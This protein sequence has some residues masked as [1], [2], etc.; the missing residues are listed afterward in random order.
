M[1]SMNKIIALITL[2]SLV[3]PI[4]ASGKLAEFS[5]KAQGKPQIA[6]LAESLSPTVVYI[7]SKEKARAMPNDPF[8]Y[9][10]GNP[11]GEQ[12]PRMR[13]GAGSGVLVSSEGHIIT[14]YHVIQDATEIQVTLNDERV[15]DAEIVGTDP[16]I[17]LAVLK[18]KADHLTYAA[19]G[20]SS[21]LR[22]GE[23]VIAIGAPLGYR[24]TV[25]Q[26]IISALNRGG[27][28]RLNTI[29]NYIQTDAA[30]NRGN[31]GGPLIDMN[32]KIIG[33]NTAISAMGQNIGFAVPID[34]IKSSYAQIME[35]GTVSRGALG[36]TI[37]SLSPEAKE[38]YGQTHGAIVLSVKE[39][40]PAQR[41]GLQK[42]DLILSLDGVKVRDSGHLTS[43]VA[44]RKPGDTISVDYIRDKKKK[45]LTLVLGDRASI[46]AGNPSTAP[47]EYSG[48]RN[49][50]PAHATLPNVGLELTYN[51]NEQAWIISDITP[52]STAAEKGLRKG[53][54]ILSINQR[55]LDSENASSIFSDFKDS[56]DVLLIEIENSRG[57]QMIF[58]KPQ[59]PEK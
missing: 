25:T 45:T 24:Y 11:H 46:I 35:K 9:F 4:Q 51:V 44:I 38:W 52:G 12:N 42:G 14:N 16:E 28:V 50:N 19:L 3:V 26:G 8:H 32:G 1:N 31:S 57:T 6:D 53:W 58:L 33:I 49:S 18:I 20:D 23:W 21:R 13:L 22:V 17:D 30:I 47:G 54:K 37:R 27:S 2:I 43:M 40:S 48:R 10:F 36:V 59:P 41:D 7:E 55:T 34:L 39:D 29:E 15:F 5:G 56:R